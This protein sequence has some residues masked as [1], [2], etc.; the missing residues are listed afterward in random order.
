[1]LDGL[2]NA[3]VPVIVGAVGVLITG[4]CAAILAVVNR[5]LGRLGA[6]ADAK[7]AQVNEDRG[8]DTAADAVVVVEKTMP[9]ATNAAKK[10]AAV[11]LTDAEPATVTSLQIDAAAVV[12]PPGNLGPAEDGGPS[13]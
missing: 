7:A 10:A 12:L 6:V 3:L 1:M 5:Y 2:Q 11:V 8:R 4:L 13:G 9:N